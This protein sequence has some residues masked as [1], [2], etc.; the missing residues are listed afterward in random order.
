MCFLGGYSAQLLLALSSEG[1]GRAE[2]FSP[3]PGLG[4]RVSRENR[5]S[6]GHCQCLGVICVN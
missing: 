6:L 4:V 3:R 5:D 2:P 1:A